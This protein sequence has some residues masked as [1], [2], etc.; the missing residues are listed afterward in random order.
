V[1]DATIR[2]ARLPADEPA[3]LSFIT[4]LQD[5][6]GAFESDRRRDPN[7]A[8]EHWRDVQHRCAEMHGIFL[9]A[10]EDGRPVGWTFAHDIPG[11]LFVVAPER[12]HGSIAELFVVPEARGKGLGRALIEGCEAWARGRGHQLLALGVLARNARA[13]RAYEGAGFTPYTLI[14]RRYL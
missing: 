14:L 9:I 8:V 12:R 10:E 5:Y 4:G 1:R 6:E 2:E 11:H 7:F 3:I 13:I